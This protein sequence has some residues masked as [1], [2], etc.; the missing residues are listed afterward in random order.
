MTLV[1]TVPGVKTKE[2]FQWHANH[3]NLN[4]IKEL[5]ILRGYV[6]LVLTFFTILFNER[7][8]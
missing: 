5:L 1:D 8:N 4:K 2:R 7:R 6:R 3:Q